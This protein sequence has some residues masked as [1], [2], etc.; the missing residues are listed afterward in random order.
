MYGKAWW[1]NPAY[2]PV[3]GDP[4]DSEATSIFFA[5]ENTVAEV[6]T[7]VGPHIAR[8]DPGRVLREVAAKRRILARHTG[9]HACPV[10]AEE[11]KAWEVV[12]DVDDLQQ[13]QATQV[14]PR[15]DLRDPA[16]PYSSHEGYR[17][18]W[19]S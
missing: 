19:E 18:G 6:W 7:E 15:G 8:H 5:G 1:W 14:I 16:K 2:G 13:E 17:Q 4:N 10:P 11:P 3:K 12:I 9:Q